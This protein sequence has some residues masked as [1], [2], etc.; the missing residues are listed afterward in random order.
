MKI[1]NFTFY[2]YK[3]IYIFLSIHQFDNFKKG[4]EKRIQSELEGLINTWKSQ[5]VDKFSK[6]TEELK[7]YY[8]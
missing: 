7:E 2:K 6:S 5:I 1:V 3:Y 4:I 8:K